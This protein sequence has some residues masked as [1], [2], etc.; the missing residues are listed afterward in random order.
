MTRSS[1]HL[2]PE[3]HDYVVAHSAPVDGVLRDL[4]AETE[5]RFPAQVGLQIGPEQGGFM[6]LFTRLIGAR[7]AVEV[8]TFTGYSSICVARGLPEDGTLLACDV[9]EEWTS[10]ARRYWDRAGVAGKVTLR[11]GPAIDTLRALPAEPLFDLAFIDADKEGYI[12]YWEELVPRI[13]PGGALL[14][15]NT[16]SHGR[17]VDPSVTLPSVEGIRA[18]NAHARDDDRVEQVL[19][20]IGDGLT[21]ARRR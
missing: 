3:L 14:V 1:E 6:T 19:L 13:R 17:V 20:P 2:S 4:V 15:D 16:L 8:G 9:S 21:V 11:L 7:D 5:R 12:A 18:F 10:V